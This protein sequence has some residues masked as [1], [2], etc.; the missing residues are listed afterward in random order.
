MQRANKSL[1]QK[2]FAQIKRQPK[3]IYLQ[4]DLFE[5]LMSVEPYSFDISHENN[6]KLREQ[7]AY[8][9]KFKYNIENFF[10]LYKKSLLF[11]AKYDLDSYLQYLEIEREPKDRFYLPR[12]DV[13]RSDVQALQDLTDNKLD[14]LF[15]AKPPRVGK[16]SLLMFYVTWLIGR[17]SEKSNLYSAYSDT[18]TKAFYNG[19]LETIQDPDTYKWEDVFP[20]AKL[21]QTNAQEE[22]INIDRKKRYPSLTCRSL[23]GTLNGACDCNGILITDD[24]IGGIEEALNPDRMI[25]AWSKVDNNLLTRAKEGAKILW[26]GTRWSIIDPAGIRMELLE[27]DE[28]FKSRRYK[29]INTPALDGKDQSNFKYDYGVGF[30]TEF[31]HQKR[32]S[33]ERNND[34]A[35]WQA[36][37]MGEPVERQ[38]TLFEPD[39]LR[40]F[41]SPPEGEPDRIFMA[42]DPAYGGGDFVAAPVCAV[43]GDDIY[44]LDT[45]YDN[46]NKYD[47]Q[48]L[49]VN[50]VAKYG[51]TTMQIEAN[52]ATEGYKDGVK[53]K[54]QKKGI[55]INLTTKPA[56]N[57]KS[58]EQRIFDKAPD[59]REY[60]LFKESGQRSKPYDMFMQSVFSFKITGK[61]KHDD[62]PDSLSMAIDM[63]IGR[64]QRA[65]VFKRIF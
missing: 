11:E 54:L 51:V 17:D 16:T 38:G 13:L 56:P 65:E 58:K 4:E 20:E 59:I 44:V 63:A 25:N 57:N 55:S 41:V 34:I 14:E 35:S 52:K 42:V 27:N 10:E 36:Q 22:T 18:I 39:S 62:A 60:M 33:F 37:Y 12:R 19:V 24:L 6:L 5:Y 30:S 45:V 7:I 8:S 40:Y 15:L 29:I 48:M 2:Y 53:D 31:Y 32:A 46:G 28:K 47:T 64:K 26:V 9:M 23:Y 1:I 49:L 3:D 21:V 50:A 61:N 43:Y